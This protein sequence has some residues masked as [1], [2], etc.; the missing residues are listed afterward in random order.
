MERHGAPQASLELLARQRV[1][2]VGG[3][4]LYS[5]PRRNL[6]DR[7]ARTE[8]ELQDLQTLARCRTLLPRLLLHQPV[9]GLDERD[10]P[11][12]VKDLAQTRLAR[13]QLLGGHVGRW[14]PARPLKPALR[15]LGHVAHNAAEK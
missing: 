15:T 14:A 6:A 10:S 8:A 1:R 11:L 12:A 3:S 2:L 7:Q 9:R 4:H 5:E 13:G